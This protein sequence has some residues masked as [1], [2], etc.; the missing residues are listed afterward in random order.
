MTAP[1]IQLGA[2]ERAAL[3]R[4]IRQSANAQGFNLGRN[5][6][7]MGKD[8]LLTVARTFGLDVLA[9]AAEARQEA[10]KTEF[11]AAA[12]T[13]EAD[14]PTL[15]LPNLPETRAVPVTPR[16]PKRADTTDAARKLAEALAGLTG[17]AALDEDRVREIAAEEAAKATR[18]EY[19]DKIIVQKADGQKETLPDAP[20]HKVF[21]D[22]MDAVDAGLN[23]LLVG[24][25]GA[26]KTHLCEQVAQALGLPF[27]FTG[28]V[29][30]EFKLLGFKTATGEYSR[31]PFR[32]AYENGGVFLW[33]EMDGSSPSAMLAFN[34]GLANG[35][36]DFPDSCIRRHD[37]FRAIASANTFG[38]GADR[39]YVGRNQLDAASLDRFAVVEMDYDEQLERALFGDT[40]WTAHVQKVRRAV[41]ELKIRHVVSMRAIASGKALLE[42]G[43]G[44]AKV[45]S[46]VLWKGLDT[47]T[48]TKIREN[49]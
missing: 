15:P 14:D 7:D 48:V 33:D 16:A 32:D 11:P 9:I 43:W 6:S 5:P 44:H 1:N 34:A 4:A 38:R 13:D 21:S 17:G 29:A 36:Q 23:V 8:E 24:P 31:T 10:A 30:S 18:I 26:G 22:V 39:Q 47:A 35:Q 37:K 41:A 3:K 28:A 27:H 42:K 12:D 2:A 49:I 46:A 20:R 40:E 19:R 45:E 25:A